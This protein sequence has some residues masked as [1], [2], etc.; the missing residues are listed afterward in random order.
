MQFAQPHQ[1]KLNQELL[2]MQQLILLIAQIECK[3]YV[4]L[5]RNQSSKLIEPRKN[6]LECFK[7]NGKC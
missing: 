1:A 2:K 4:L 5:N 6:A 3:I 7:T